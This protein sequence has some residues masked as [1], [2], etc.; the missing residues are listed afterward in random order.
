MSPARL[1]LLVLSLS[2]SAAVA[3]PSPHFV[4]RKTFDAIVHE[5]SGEHAQEL[6][7]RI[8]AYH[9]IQGSPMM[10]DVA[11]SVVVPALRAA[12]LETRVE[13]FPS[14]G[15]TRYQTYRSPLAWR[16]RDGELWIEGDKPE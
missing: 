5:L 14:D 15:K 8:V 11:E 13:K 12:G 4:D 16:M 6:D 3:D 9:R 1:T 2:S 7:R 10:A